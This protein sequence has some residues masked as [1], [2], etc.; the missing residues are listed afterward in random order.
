MDEGVTVRPILAFFAAFL[1]L[2]G[3]PL[4]A[5]LPEGQHPV[6]ASLIAETKGFAPGQAL[7]VALRLEQENG[8]HTYWKDPGDAGL[9]TTVDWDLP[10]GVKAGP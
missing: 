1:A 6:K 7:T 4:G 3:A 8:W 5:A 2:P 9:A 10:A